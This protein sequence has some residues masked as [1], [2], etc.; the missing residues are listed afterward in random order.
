[1]NQQELYESQLSQMFFL[2][3]EE[4]YLA[5]KQHCWKGPAGTGG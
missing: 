4:G 5:E 3:K 1:M 2:E